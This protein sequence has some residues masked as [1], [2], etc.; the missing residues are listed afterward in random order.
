MTL[1]NQVVSLDLAKKLKELGVKQESLFYW[2]AVERPKHFK[3]KNIATVN[4]NAGKE[5]YMDTYFEW[6]VRLN[7]IKN[8]LS[9]SAFTVAEL[10]KMLPHEVT[11]SKRWP[12]TTGTWKSLLIGLNNNGL[13]Q[14]DHIEI[15]GTEADAR[16]KMLIYL[17]ENNLHKF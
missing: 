12:K 17:L 6:T 7:E 5:G 9:L 13:I 2:T 8:D 3:T 1:E 10:G 14:D 15:G 4:P 16:A 11:S